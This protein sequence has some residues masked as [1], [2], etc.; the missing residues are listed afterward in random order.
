MGQA[1]EAAERRAEEADGEQDQGVADQRADIARQQAV[2]DDQLGEIRLQQRQA[3]GGDRE[4]QDGEE[5]PGMRPDE[6]VEPAERLPVA[7]GVRPGQVA[8]R[9]NTC[10]VA[11]LMSPPPGIMIAPIFCRVSGS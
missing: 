2:V 7:T 6:T 9:L 10:T 4:N 8:Q 3:A 1:V 5:P 11:V